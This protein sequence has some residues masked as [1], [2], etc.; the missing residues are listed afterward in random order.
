MVTGRCYCGAVS[1]AFPPPET[2]A[3]CHCA[4]CRRWTGAPAPAFADMPE[5]ALRVTPPLGPGRRFPSGAVRWVCDVCGSPIAARF[6]YLPGRLYV[7]IGLLDQAADLPPTIACHTD[8]ILPWCRMGDL[9]GTAGSARD[10]LG[11]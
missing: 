2:V 10:R 5:D 9:P 6:S 3:L 8:A 11:R 4:D 1:L 7:P